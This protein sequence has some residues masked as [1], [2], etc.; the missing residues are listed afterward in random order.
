MP[1]SW[2]FYHLVW[3]TRDREPAIHPDLEPDIWRLV[4]QAAERADVLVY[5]VGGMTE[6]VHVAASIPPSL[7]V[8]EAVRRMKGGSSRSINQTTGGGFAWQA[9][10]GVVSFAERNLSAVVA[11]A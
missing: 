4:R 6:H 11:I 5:A 9:E 7:S 2:L 3:A 10:Y 8:A 1:Y